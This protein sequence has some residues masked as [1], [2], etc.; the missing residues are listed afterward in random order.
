MTMV[1]GV[2]LLAALPLYLGPYWLYVLAIGFYYATLA[3]SWALLAGYVGQISFAHAAFAAIGAYTASL[4]LIHLGW[5]PLAGILLGAV[6]AA[7][8]GLGLGVTTLKL[9]GPYLALTTIAFSEILRI[10]LT[11]EAEFTRGSYG[12][13]VPALFPGTSRIPYY[14]T[15]LALAAGTLSVLYAVVKSPVGLHLRAIREDEEGAAA[16]GVPVTRYKVLAVAM[17]SFFAGLAGGFYAPFVQLVSPQMSSIT[18]MATILAMAVFGG[19]ESL[20]GAASGALVLQLLSEGL[21]AYPEWRLVIYGAIVLATIRYL[22]NGVAVTAFHA[23]RGA[24]R[25]SRALG[26]RGSPVPG[27]TE[28]SS[29]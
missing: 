14:Y 15:M 9:K 5:H 29:Q 13:P 7:L 3:S 2:A 4:T 18:E 8:V 25:H 16:R 26:E 21:R 22:P 6:L 28:R 27:E 1:A 12:L 11:A 17:S 20:L 23:L 24:R 10:A 19:L